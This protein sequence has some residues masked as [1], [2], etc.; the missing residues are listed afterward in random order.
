MRKESEELGVYLVADL[1]EI[2]GVILEFDTV[3]VKYEQAVPVPFYP[4]LVL[5]VKSGNIIY[6]YALLVLASPLLYLSL[7]HI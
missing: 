1:L 4:F 3:H 2:L 7:I 5:L 6:A